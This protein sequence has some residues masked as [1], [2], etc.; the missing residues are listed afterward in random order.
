MT[1]FLPLE[2]LL[3]GSRQDNA[4]PW[5]HW[6]QRVDQWRFLLQSKEGATW[7]LY[8]NDAFEFST[9]LFAL[10]S[11]GK[12][13]CVP[14]SNQPVVCH[15]LRERVA[16]FIGDFPEEFAPFVIAAPQPD[17]DVLTG[18]VTLDRLQ[19]VMEIF[20]SGSSGEPQAVGKQL[21]QLSEEVSNLE[22]LWR[23][24]AQGSQVAATV[25]HHHIY[26][27]LFRILWP[28]AAGRPFAALAQEYLEEL[29]SP[30][31]EDRPLIL[32]SS[33]SHLSRIL[34]QT[35]WSSLR[36]RC[37]A[38]FSSGAPLSRDA[39][40][41]AAQHLGF[42]PIEV[43]GSSETGGIAW[44]QQDAQR[45]VAW[46]AVPGVVIA[47]DDAST[48]L[49][50]QS[51]YLSPEPGGE[52]YLTSDRVEL[53]SDS[54]FH[55]RG[56]VD[57]IA[58]VE[59]KRVSLTE[60]EQRLETHPLV[61]QARVVVLEGRRSELAAVVVLSQDGVD[62]LG[63]KGRRELNNLLGDYLLQ[64]FE[65]PVLPRRWRYPS[66]L[67]TNSQGKVTQ[68]LLAELFADKAS[69]DSALNNAAS[70]ATASD[71]EHARP[72]LPDVLEVIRDGS[73]LRLRLHVPEDLL[74]F[75]GHFPVAAI[76]PGVVQL[77]WARHFGGEHLGFQG[78]FSH[79]EAIK[80]Q[81]VVRPLQELHLE[82]ELKTPD[83]LSFRYYST[84]GQ[85]ASGRIVNHR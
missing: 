1:E 50:I 63:D 59:G 40:L 33:P 62:L 11:L 14:G 49:K 51:P 75:E 5:R 15:K 24:L 18:P 10:W 48:C 84:A 36:K 67:P 57:R 76:L 71:T 3:D 7:A 56:R 55:L 6:R 42:A 39:S 65:R 32:I 73:K 37:R 20:T 54:E 53:V 34:P 2:R 16:G 31:E 12:I 8:N 83:K 61:K 9:A 66:S 52:W 85:H 29:N 23:E 70:T 68:D 69:T 58:K 25:S 47:V 72:V 46:T 60:V 64:Q 4:S 43:Y 79:L 21:Y 45:E 22:R 26:G 13:A 44:R 19:P 17:A 80:F 30:A 77:K 27:L 35:D 41:S 78:D 28:L 38:I 74:Y 82:L 81:H